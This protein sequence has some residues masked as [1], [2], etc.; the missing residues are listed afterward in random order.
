MGKVAQ[1]GTRM[2]PDARSGSTWAVT[3]AATSAFSRRV[4]AR[5]VAPPMR[6]RLVMRLIRLS[7]ILA[8]EPTPM[9]TTRAPIGQMG[10]DSGAG[11]PPPPAR[12]R[13]R[14]GHGRPHRPGRW[15]PSRPAPRPRPAGPGRGR[16]R[17][18]W[19]RSPAASCTPAVPTPPAAPLT[20]TRSPMRSWPWVKRASKAVEKASGKPPAS[21]QGSRSGTASACDSSTTAKVG[22]APPPTR[23]MTRSP[24]ANWRTCGADGDH[25]AGQLHAWDVG[26]EPGGAG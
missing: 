6:A 10:Q 23:A 24:G 7:S 12:A 21:G 11:W 5:R 20:S 26:G 2:R 13:R 3:A 8:P 22:L 15:P 18:P 19:P 9:T 16:W 4:R 17:P 1:T 14:R 25:L